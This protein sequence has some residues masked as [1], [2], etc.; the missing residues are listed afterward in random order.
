MPKSD[1]LTAMDTFIRTKLQPSGSCIICS[2]TFSADHQPVALACN[3][4]FGHRCI[5][6]WLHHGRG[7]TNSCPICRHEIYT[8]SDDHTSAC[9]SIWAALCAR[10]PER[11]HDFMTALWPRVSALCKAEPDGSFSVRDLLHR[12]VLPALEEV[13]EQYKNHG[14]FHDCQSLIVSTRNSSDRP[15]PASGLIIPLV[16]LTRLMTQTSAILP[17][18]ITTVQRTSVLFWRANA[19]LGVSTLGISWAHIGEAAQLANPRYFPLLHLYTVLLSQNIVHSQPTIPEG[20][21]HATILE[22]CCGKIGGRWEGKPEKGFKE[23]VV[24]VYEA[25]RR[26]Q[27]DE[28]RISLRGHEEEKGVVTG[29]WAMVAWRKEDGGKSRP[30]LKEQE[31]VPGGWSD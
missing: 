19:C 16:R 7:N 31:N 6:K 30:V 11:I 8:P 26:H 14:P 21:T 10:S 29:L 28:K 24:A 25:L 22:R 27:L 9:S 15:N 18:W 20:L 5:K 23:S 1:D 17:K 13:A 4:I 12:A 2:D 3:H